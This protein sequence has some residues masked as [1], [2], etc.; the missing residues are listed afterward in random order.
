M[1]STGTRRSSSSPA[2]TAAEDRRQEQ[3]RT[4]REV[5]LAREDHHGFADRDAGPIMSRMGRIGAARHLNQIAARLPLLSGPDPVP[6]LLHG[7]SQQSNFVSGPDGATVIDVAPYFG[8][9]EVDLALVDVFSPVQPELFSAYAQLAPV[10][11]GFA[12]R[13]ALPR[14]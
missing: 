12:G 8:H 14:K 11:P 3:A 2:R 4:H 13:R 6:A 10:D 5:D 7:D 9:P 1:G